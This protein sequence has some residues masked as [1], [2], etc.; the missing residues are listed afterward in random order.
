MARNKITEEQLFARKNRFLGYKICPRCG[1]DL[2]QAVLD[3]RPRLQCSNDSCDFIYYHNPIPAAGGVIVDNG[4]ILLVKRGMMPKIGWW[5]LPAG[6]MEW[7]EH[8]SQT[9]IREVKEETGLEIELDGIFEVYSGNDDPRMNAVLILYLG[10][11]TGGELRAGDDA[12][13]V[14][15]FPLDKPPENIAF[16]S[17]IQAINDYNRRYL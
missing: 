5:C 8:P 4:K 7:N 12:V 17:H 10:R 2:H 3:G 16:E 13:E 11:I 1:S 9:A 15:W 14:A 6:F